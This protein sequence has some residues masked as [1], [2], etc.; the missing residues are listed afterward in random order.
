MNQGCHRPG[1]PAV[2][3]VLLLLAAIVAAPGCSR[4][5]E[6]PPDAAATQLPATPS[7]T[8]ALVA[9]STTTTAVA[10]TTPTV[11]P[12]QGS[13]EQDRV[14]LLE[15]YA[16]A[17]GLSWSVSR[18]WLIYRPLAEWEG[19]RTDGDG[20]V[21]RLDLRDDGLSG[22]IPESLGSLT[23]LETLTLHDNK[24]GGPIPESSVPGSGVT[25]ADD[26]CKG[27][28]VRPQYPGRR[29]LQRGQ[30]RRQQPCRWTVG[31]TAPSFTSVEV[32]D[33]G[34][35]WSERA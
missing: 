13:T 17:G 28:Q 19:V 10:T 1:G 30:V 12:P 9:I 16:A 34:Q 24:L 32:S 8:A 20:R 31:T 33:G 26:L 22:S 7:G 29:S 14:A 4:D 23:N 3:G 27:D 25:Q 11:T 21:V 6:E 5:D 18:P 35:R 15:L 2:F